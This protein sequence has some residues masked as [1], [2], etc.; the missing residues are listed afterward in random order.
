MRGIALKQNLQDTPLIS[1]VDELIASA[2]SQIDTTNHERRSLDLDEITEMIIAYGAGKD[3][4]T[5]KAILNQSIVEIVGE[6]IRI[7]VPTT[8]AR[9]EIQQEVELFGHI[10]EHFNQHDLLIDVTVDRDKFPD[11]ELVTQKKIFTP[12]EKYDHLV[13][14]NPLVADLISALNLK[15]DQEWTELH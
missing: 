10:R 13:N 14:K 4:P 6:E 5:T 11:I 9:E 3:S 8:I 12:K 7:F 2:Q 1:S 15:V